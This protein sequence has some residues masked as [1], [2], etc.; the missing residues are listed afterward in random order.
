MGDTWETTFQA[1]AQPPGKTGQERCENSES[2]IRNAIKSSE[3]LSQRYIRVFT[4]GSYRNR[5][6]VRQDSD[7]DIGVCCYDVFFPSYP[8]GTTKETFGN[9][10]G[11]YQLLPLK[12]KWKRLWLRTLVVVRLSVATRHLI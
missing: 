8:K 6:N 11:D 3:K 7:I 2:A 5:V 12:T 1:W 9:S 4:Q 10:D